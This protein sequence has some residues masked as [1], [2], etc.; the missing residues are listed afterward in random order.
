MFEIIEKP[1]GTTQLLFRNNSTEVHRIKVLE[2]GYCSIH[3]HDKKS[4]MFYV[5]SGRLSIYEQDEHGFNQCVTVLR[6]GD[7]LTIPSGRYHEFR[8]TEDTIAYE[9]YDVDP[10]TEQDISRLNV[11]GRLSLKASFESDSL[12]V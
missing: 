3:K 2:G 6:D 10:I 8:A 12:G 9:I 11:G 5:E 4:N 7:A 1:W